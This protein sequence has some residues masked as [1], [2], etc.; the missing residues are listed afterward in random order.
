MPHHDTITDFLVA[1]G[2]CIDQEQRYFYRYTSDT[3]RQVIPFTA[4]PGHTVES[5][6]ALLQTPSLRFR[7]TLVFGQWVGTIG[8]SPLSE[9]EITGY[10]GEIMTP[11]RFI[12]GEQGVEHVTIMPMKDLGLKLPQRLSADCSSPY[13]YQDLIGKVR[14]F[15]DGQE[16]Q[17]RCREVNVEEGYCWLYDLN[18]QGRKFLKN[19]VPSKSQYFGKVEIRLKL[20]AIMVNKKCRWASFPDLQ[21][22]PIL[23]WREIPY[24]PDA[25]ERMVLKYVK[26]PEEANDENHD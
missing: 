11:V 26:K 7:E 3:E 19:G 24:V 22:K 2:F 12:S 13:F 20:G 9:Q 1:I 15:L 21:T 23:S 16:V 25:R 8:T 18:E 17:N 6:K 5:F 4:L 10:T 14:V